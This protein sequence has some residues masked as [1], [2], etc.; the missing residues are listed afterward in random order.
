MTLNPKYS[1]IFCIIALIISALVGAPAALGDAFGSYAHAVLAWLILFNIVINA[2]NT[3]L[4][5]IPSTVPANPADA[6]KFLLG[7]KP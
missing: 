3:A 2:I 7:P 6:S 5:M 1:A 4:H